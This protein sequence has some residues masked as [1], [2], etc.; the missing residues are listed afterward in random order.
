L[1]YYICDKCKKEIKNPLKVRLLF[2]VFS[3][4][5]K[6]KKYKFITIKSFQIK[7]DFCEKCSFDILNELDKIIKE[8][9]KNG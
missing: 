8:G 9:G 4:D 1:K 5:R 7:G 3:Y 6:V 2:Q